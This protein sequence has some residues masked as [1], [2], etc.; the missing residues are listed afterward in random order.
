VLQFSGKVA[1][2]KLAAQRAYEADAY[3]R[4]ASAIVLR[5][6]DTS[7][8]LKRY[9]EAA[10]WCERGRESFPSEWTFRMCRLSLMAWSP[11]VEADV[12][13][14]WQVL[15]EIDTVAAPGDRV[16]LRPQMTMMVAAVVAAAGL[17]DS[18]ERVID[19]ARAEAPADPALTYYEALARVRL[20]QR[21]EAAE[22]LA[23]LLR[24]SPIF[25][26]F[27]RSHSAFEPLWSDPRLRRWSAAR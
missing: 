10:G 26:A 11:E 17:R 21:A 16:W 4:D 23:T 14:A 13:A 2:S 24:R 22:R 3:L 18:A 1:E 20:G 9:S 19:R 5:L 6:F 7:L 8:E 25:E 15:A 27:L 12:P